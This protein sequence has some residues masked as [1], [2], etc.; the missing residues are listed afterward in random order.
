MMDETGA[1]LV[2]AVEPYGLLPLLFMGAGI[3]VVVVLCVFILPTWRKNLEAQQEIE[4]IKAEAQIE[5]ERKREERKA[6]DAERQAQMD[7]ERAEIDGR[8]AV[9]TEGLKTSID[10]MRATL[11]RNNALLEGS[12]SGSAKMGETVEDTNRLVTEIHHVIVK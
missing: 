12:R 4:R 6:A 10:A 11:D 3:A 2:E 9:T 1:A 5:L 7:K 8:N